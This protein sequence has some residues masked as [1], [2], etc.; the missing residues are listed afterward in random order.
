M[1]RRPSP[2]PW[3]PRPRRA[4]LVALAALVDDDHA[5]EEERLAAEGG[6]DVLR[7][8]D[9]GR[10]A[11]GDQPAVEQR[12]ELEALGGGRPCRACSRAP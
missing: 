10:R 4:R 6:A 1:R 9:L 5:L 2:S 11:V 3:R 8:E 7:R 12:D